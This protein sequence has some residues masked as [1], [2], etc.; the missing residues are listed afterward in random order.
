L[1]TEEVV[2]V[3]VVEV[4]EEGK[5]KNRRQRSLV[6][7]ERFLL[8]MDFSLHRPHLHSINGGNPRTK[9]TTEAGNQ[10]TLISQENPNSI[11]NRKKG[12]GK[13]KGKK[14]G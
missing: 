11:S 7:L 14:L 1:E 9:K 12:K 5:E 3:E 4:V 6:D 10:T 13:G 2:V 8:V